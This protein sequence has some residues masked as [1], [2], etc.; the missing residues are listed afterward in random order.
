M[1]IYSTTTKYEYEYYTWGANPGAKKE[2][3][4]RAHYISLIHGKSK[5]GDYN[6]ETISIFFPFDSLS[7]AGLGVG[8]TSY[9]GYDSLKK[10]NGNTF[11]YI[12][13][14]KQTK[15]ACWDGFTVNYYWA[16]DVG[17]IRKENINKGESWDL[18]SYHVEK[19]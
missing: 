11:H 19:Q 2:A 18:V 6:G 1:L 15:D 3:L 14:F 8:E 7:K 16:K 12:Q 10:I 13:I 9:E 17:L 5:P 4:E